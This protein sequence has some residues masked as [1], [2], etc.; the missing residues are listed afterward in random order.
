MTGHSLVPRPI[1]KAG[2]PEELVV[3]AHGNFDHAHVVDDNVGVLAGTGPLYSPT[4]PEFGVESGFDFLWVALNCFT[5][6]TLNGCGC[7]SNKINHAQNSRLC[8]I[9][10]S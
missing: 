10:I 5:L 2:L 3:A 8:Q 1:S 6:M 7:L 4:Y 9:K